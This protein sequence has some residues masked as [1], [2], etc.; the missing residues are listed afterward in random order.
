MALL[1]LLLGATSGA[2][3]GTQTGTLRGFVRDSQGLVMPVVSI[4]AS[5]PALQGERSTVTGSD[6][7]Y[8]SRSAAAKS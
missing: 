3:Q 7:A 1:I 4:T 8:S 5:S 2:A 6:G